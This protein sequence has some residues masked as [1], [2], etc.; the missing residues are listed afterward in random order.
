MTENRINPDSV[1]AQLRGD[2]GKSV[3]LYERRLGAF[4]VILPIFH[5]DGDMIDVYLQ[6][7]PVGGGMIRVCD[8][9]MTLM[10]LSYSYEISKP[11]RK[12]IL[13]S[14]LAHNGGA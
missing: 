10:R 6:S 12:R 8:F 11:T 1:I 5:E 4:Q 3:A 7:S 13:N 9:G 2:F 14:I